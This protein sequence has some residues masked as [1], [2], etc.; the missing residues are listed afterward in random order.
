[1]TSSC[2]RAPCKNTKC[3]VH[4]IQ[5]AWPATAHVKG[6]PDVTSQLRSRPPLDSLGSLRLSPHASFAQPSGLTGWLG[7]VAGWLHSYARLSGR[8]HRQRLKQT[9][10]PITQ[11]KCMTR[12]RV[13]HMNTDRDGTELQLKLPHL[14]MVML[15]LA[16]CCQLSLAVWHRSL[17]KMFGLRPMAARTSKARPTHRQCQAIKYSRR[18][19]CTSHLNYSNTLRRFQIISLQKGFSNKEINIQKQERKEANI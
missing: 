13:A 1:M 16:A 18:D 15:L 6:A 4:N 17:A 5:W 9:M 12:S 2:L 7:W 3:S 14:T 8:R 10:E 11:L 19:K